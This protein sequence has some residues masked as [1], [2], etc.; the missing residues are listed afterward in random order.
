MTASLHDRIMNLP[1]RIESNAMTHAERVFYKSGHQD[2]RHA[3]A[4]LAAE[5]DVPCPCTIADEP[6]RPECACVKQ[7]SSFGCLCCARYG[8]EEGRKRAA[9]RIVQ[10][11]RTGWHPRPTGPGLWLFLHGLEGDSDSEAVRLSQ[12]REWEDP[13]FG[14]QC[15]GPIPE[16]PEEQR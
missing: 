13:L 7:H 1:C 4:E 3:A 12:D 11:C 8:N 6:C 15:F 10:A 14:R 5:A 9:N 2:A 16:P